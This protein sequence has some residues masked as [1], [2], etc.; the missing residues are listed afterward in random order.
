MSISKKMIDQLKTDIET[1]INRKISTPKDFSFLRDS[2][3][4]RLHVWVGRSTLMRLWNYID[5]KVEPRE[6]TLDV[7]SRYLGYKDWEEYKQNALLPKE[8]QSS[9]VLCRKLSVLEDLAIGDRIRLTWQ[10]GRVCDIEYLGDLKFLVVESEKTLLCKGDTF[11]CSLIVE[12]EPLYLDNLIHDNR[13][14]VAYICGM[15]SGVRFEHLP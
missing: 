4:A 3:F 10:P 8:R 13:P 7:L 1:A 15:Q 9:L 11:Q 5:N 12:G 6:S 14:P 2:I